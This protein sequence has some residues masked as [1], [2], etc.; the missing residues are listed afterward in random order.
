MAFSLDKL[1]KSLTMKTGDPFI[2]FRNMKQHF[3]AEEM[4]LIARKGFYPYEFVDDHSKLNYSGLPPKESF[5]SKVR[6]D[7]ISDADYEHAKTYTTHSSAKT[8]ETITGYT[9]KQMCFC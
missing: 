2:K 7:D 6:L 3:N 5:Y 4:K 8:L 9:L 1:V